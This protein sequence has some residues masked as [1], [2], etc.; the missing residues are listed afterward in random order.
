VHSVTALVAPAVGNE[1][2]LPFPPN[3]VRFPALGDSAHGLGEAFSHSSK[4]CTPRFEASRRG[5]V[6]SD[7]LSIAAG[8][9]PGREKRLD[10][11][12][13]R[14]W[15][16][17]GLGQD[18]RRELRTSGAHNADALLTSSI[19]HSSRQREWNRPA[20]RGGGN[21]AAAQQ[22]EILKQMFHTLSSRGSALPLC[23]RQVGEWRPSRSPRLSFVAVARH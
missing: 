20:G 14:H 10:L 22:P 15:G 9:V 1:A 12:G 3:S 4:T 7:G 8:Q 6:T 23:P 21:F 18:R 16:S 13:A 19:V 17:G 5:T 11:E 2:R